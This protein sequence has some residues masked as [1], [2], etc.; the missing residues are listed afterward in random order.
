M[1]SSRH[2]AFLVIL[3]FGSV[4]LLIRSLEEIVYRLVTGTRITLTDRAA[5]FGLSHNIIDT[6]AERLNIIFCAFP[7]YDNELVAA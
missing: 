7:A 5:V 1:L 6:V 2:A 4:H 3:L